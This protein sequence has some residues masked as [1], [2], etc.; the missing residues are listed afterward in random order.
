MLTCFGMIWNYDKLSRR[1]T[2]SGKIYALSK[3]WIFTKLIVKANMTY[4]GTR[5]KIYEK[6]QNISFENSYWR[7]Q[8]YEQKDSKKDNSLKCK[9]N[10]LTHYMSFGP[11]YSNNQF[12]YN[13]KLFNSPKK[14][15]I[16]NIGWI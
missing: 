7:N 14:W 1:N 10:T 16:I 15:I 5:N 13:I 6:F 12:N 4:W 11:S 9:V 2:K 8:F 3:I